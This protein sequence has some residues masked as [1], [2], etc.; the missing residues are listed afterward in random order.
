MGEECCYDSG[1][2]MVKQW[3]W[4]TCTG[5]WEVKK[6]I[7]KKIKIFL[8]YFFISFSTLTYFQESYIIS[9]LQSAYIPHWNSLKK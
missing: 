9:T 4:R 5:E 2:L 8:K 3:W 6:I 1:L 7:S